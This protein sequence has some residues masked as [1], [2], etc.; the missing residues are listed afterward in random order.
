LPIPSILLTPLLPLH[1]L[2]HLPQSSPP[3]SSH[4]SCQ[5]FPA[6]VSLHLIVNPRGQP[7]A[8]VSGSEP[9]HS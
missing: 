4:P 8:A 5:G 7:P 3:T 1:S 2:T 9:P 6:T